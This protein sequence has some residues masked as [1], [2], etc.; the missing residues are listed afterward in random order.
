MCKYFK[1][2]VLLKSNNVVICD[3]KEQLKD[4]LDWYVNHPDRDYWNVKTVELMSDFFDNYLN[5]TQLGIYVDGYNTLD[6]F[7]KHDKY[8]CIPYQECLC[9]SPEKETKHG[10]NIEF[11]GEYATYE[12]FDLAQNLLSE[13]YSVDLKMVERQYTLKGI[14]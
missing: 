1:E 13:G 8:T 9:A 10:I 2:E 3:T 6:Y 5:H 4:V 11:V 14:K 12:I 7:Q